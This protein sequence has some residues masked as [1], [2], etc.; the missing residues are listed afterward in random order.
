MILSDD[1]PE[2]RVLSALLSANGRSVTEHDLLRSAFGS[3]LPQGARMQLRY[4]IQFLRREE[5]EDIEP[6]SEGWRIVMPCEAGRAWASA[7]FVS[8]L[9]DRA[10]VQGDLFGEVEP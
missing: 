9:E 3:D 8:A 1:K 2:D 5:G 4:L 10:V 6:T 7:D